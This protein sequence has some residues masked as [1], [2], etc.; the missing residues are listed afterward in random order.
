M[1]EQSLGSIRQ[2]HGFARRQCL[3]AKQHNLL[4][5]KH[6][7]R[8]CLLDEAVSSDLPNHLLSRTPSFPASPVLPK[9]K[10]GISLR[11]LTSTSTPQSSFG[12]DRTLR[13][14]R[15]EA[16]RSPISAHLSQYFRFLTSEWGLRV[17]F[18]PAQLTE[19]SDLGFR[20]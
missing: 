5:K 8:G 17:F 20:V 4:Q 1:V 12:V 6:A 3:P 2:R 15:Q 19:V 11:T 10:P 9:S 7:S 13:Q 18:P 16:A 14:S